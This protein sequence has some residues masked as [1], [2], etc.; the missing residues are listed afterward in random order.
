MRGITLLGDAPVR[1][2]ALPSCGAP[3]HSIAHGGEGYGLGA[4]RVARRRMAGGTPA[5]RGGWGARGRWG[6]RR[7][8]M[9]VV[10]CVAPRAP[11]GHCEDGG[12]AAWPSAT[13]LSGSRRFPAAAGMLRRRTRV[14][15]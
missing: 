5:P 11:A 12:A 3:R 4:G 9:G 10:Y 8:G 6:N 13:A 15:P 14:A 2:I 7:A 1:V